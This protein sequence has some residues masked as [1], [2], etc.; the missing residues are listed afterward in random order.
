MSANFQPGPRPLPELAACPFCGCSGHWAVQVEEGE[1]AII[2][3]VCHARGPKAPLSVLA[4]HAWNRR[5]E[6]NE[7][8]PPEGGKG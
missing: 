7:P 2:C 4:I 3:S 1:F 8:V 5:R 6:P